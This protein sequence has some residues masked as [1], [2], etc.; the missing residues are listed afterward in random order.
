[1]FHAVG[2]QLADRNVLNVQELAERAWPFRLHSVM[3]IIRKLRNY[4]PLSIEFRAT[5]LQR[6]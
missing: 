1:M 5:G 6:Q 4:S 3:A 2:Y